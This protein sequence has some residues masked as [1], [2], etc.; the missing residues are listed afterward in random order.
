MT[1]EAKSQ[2]VYQRRKIYDQ[3][4]MSMREEVVQTGTVEVE[5][6]VVPTEPAPDAVQT[7]D[8]ASVAG[9]VKKAIKGVGKGRAKVKSAKKKPSA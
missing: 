7:A 3:R 9:K 4:T 2:P 8:H 5:S 1:D 6:V